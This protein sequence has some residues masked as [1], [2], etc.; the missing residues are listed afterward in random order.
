V[1]NEHRSKPVK[2]KNIV[3]QVTEQ[4]KLKTNVRVPFFMVKMGLK[5]G[6]M[7]A[8]VKKTDK[9]EKELEMLKDIDMDVILEALSS[10]EISLPCVLVDVEELDKNQHVKIMLE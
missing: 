4:G 6:Q 5:F 9:H 8:N 10:G 2:P 3:I 1:E 7:A